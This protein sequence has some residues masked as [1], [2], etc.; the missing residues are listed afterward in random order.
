MWTFAM[1]FPL[2]GRER[3]EERGKTEPDC[4]CRVPLQPGQPSP[5]HGPDLWAHHCHIL[6]HT[7][8][9]ATW[10]WAKKIKKEFKVMCA[11][12]QIIE[13]FFFTLVIIRNIKYD[14]IFSRFL[15]LYCYYL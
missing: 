15:Q 14:I 12:K 13:K 1:F 10:I 5:E 4:P 7:G 2:G 6:R 9:P 3:E 11:F 8:K